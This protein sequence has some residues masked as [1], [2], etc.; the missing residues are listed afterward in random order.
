LENVG[1]GGFQIKK[2]PIEAQFSPVYA[3]ASD[4]FN[5][6][7]HLD[8]LLAGNQSVT[9]VST[10]KFDANYGIVLIGDGKGSFT[11][12]N[13]SKTGITIQGDVRDIRPLDIRQEKYY[14]F[15]RNND[16]V[17]VYKL[18]PPQIQTLGL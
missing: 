16:K 3:I 6:D 15:S 4:D 18:K 1:N 14:L 11:H 10:G 17:K 9:R 8:I 12:L 13:A 7:G 5:Q 2:L